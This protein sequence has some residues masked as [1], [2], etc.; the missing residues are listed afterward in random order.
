MRQRWLLSILLVIGLGLRTG[1]SLRT[2]PESSLI[3]LEDGIEY[4]AYARSIIDGKWDDHPRIYDLVRAPLYPLFLVP[5]EAL[6]PQKGRELT[7]SAKHHLEPPV[8]VSRGMFRAI[9]AVQVALSLATAGLVGLIA[10]RLAGPSAQI[11]ATGFMALNPFVAT[12]AGWVMTETLF[13]FL[14]WAALHQLQVFAAETGRRRT[15]RLVGAAVVL[16]LGCLC[17]PTL[18]ALL[19]FVA[20]WAG[21]VVWRTEGWRPAVAR[22]AILTAVVSTLL[23]PFQY[24][25]WR[26]HGEFNLSPGYATAVACMANSEEYY[27]TLTAGSQEEYQAHLAVLFKDYH[28]SS[29]L[30]GEDWRRDARRF[31]QEHPGEFW[32]LQMLKVLI[33]WRPWLNPKAFS[34]AFVAVSAAVMVPL[35]VFGA[36]AVASPLRRHPFCKLLLLVIAVGFITG[37][38]FFMTSVRFRVPFVDVSLMVLAAAWLGRRPWLGGQEVTSDRQTVA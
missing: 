6:T 35:F 34:P 21:W 3:E 31:R 29:G 18:Q 19:P 37:G 8:K 13:I 28:K 26:H 27:R 14:V 20:L 15:W 22:M 17:R 23:V 25:N 4:L 24:R 12:F 11:W 36:A 7:P 1:L 2:D 30:K 9:Q 32:H 33:Y 38:L 10:R 16:A 5:F